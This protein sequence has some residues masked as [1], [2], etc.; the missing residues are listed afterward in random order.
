MGAPL[1]G[2]PSIP[3]GTARPDPGEVRAGAVVARVAGRP[4]LEI[5]AL[6]QLATLGRLTGPETGRFA[7]LLEARAATFAAMARGIPESADL[8][9]VAQLD[10]RR[11][12]ALAAARARA[13]IAAGDA[14]KAI[15][16]RA[17]A[18][19]AYARAAALGGVA[20]GTP[21][22]PSMLPAAALP[23]L[24]ATPPADL[25]GWLF[26]GFTLSAR[27]LPLA[28]AFPSI[29]DDVP[30]ALA[31]ADLLLAEDPTS[32]DVRELVALVFGRARR[33]G[34]TE[35]MLMELAYDS[36]DRA[37]GLARGARVWD[38]LG[39]TREACAQWIRAARWRDDPEDPAWR[40]AV[41]CSR[42]DPGAGDWQAIRAY[43]LGRA[44]P[45][46]REAIAAALDGQ[47]AA[48]LPVAPGAGRASEPAPAPPA[49][50]AVNVIRPTR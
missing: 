8:E 17:E 1:N 43:V 45:D 32:P 6:S 27:L 7:E 39:R 18:R 42:R 14:F 38:K 37:A 22:P 50:G 48:A 25:A 33:F 41:A 36:P 49:D 5:A 30:R 16:D 47:A 28:A 13:A 40:E 23:P 11:G 4:V 21:S 2:R 15:G 46:R 3:P 24:P 10:P 31:W 26:G 44:R 29:L 19:A 35:R 34:G 20:A 9:T 12:A